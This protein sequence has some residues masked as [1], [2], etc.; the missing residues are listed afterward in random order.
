MQ[1]PVHVDDLAEAVIRVLNSPR[2]AGHYY[3]L[4]GPRPITFLDLVREAGH[5][6]GREPRILKVPL[7]P[8]AW[9]ARAWSITG[10]W[11]RIRHEQLQ[12]LQENKTFDPG[13]AADQFCYSPRDFSAGVRQEVELLGLLEPGRVS[14]AAEAGERV[15]ID[16]SR[17]P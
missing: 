14:R 10:L 11:P 7:G 4:P 8:G 6:L 1:Q 3:N 5:A 17:R 12:R 13:P 15:S 2:T 16:G 9:L